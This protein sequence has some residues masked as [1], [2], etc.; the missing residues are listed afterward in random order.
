MPDKEQSPGMLGLLQDV[1]SAAGAFGGQHI[2]HAK[3]FGNGRIF[4]I[5]HK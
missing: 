4:R 1:I 5:I 3:Y 2:M